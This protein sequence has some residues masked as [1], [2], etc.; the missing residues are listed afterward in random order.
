MVADMFCNGNGVFPRVKKKFNMAA[1]SVDLQL[2][3]GQTHASTACMVRVRA[4]VGLGRA[5]NIPSY[6]VWDSPV[7]SSPVQEKEPVAL[8]CGPGLVP[9]VRLGTSRCTK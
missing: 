5:Y 9:R 2:L 1:S 7:Q 8:R 3:Y 4:S 6:L